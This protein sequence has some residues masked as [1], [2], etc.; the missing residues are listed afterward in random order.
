MGL[1]GEIFHYN[2]QDWSHIT[3]CWLSQTS[4]YASKQHLKI[5]TNIPPLAPQCTNNQF[6]MLMFW[7]NG[8]KGTQ[9]ALLNKCWLWLKVTLADI[10]NGQGRELLTPT[11]MG[12]N[13]IELP[14][15]WHW[16]QQGRLSHKWWSLWH[17]AI[18]KC[19]PICS[20]K[21]TYPLGMWTDSLEDW[22]W[23]QN[24]LENWLAELTEY[25][26]HIWLPQWRS[27]CNWL[28]CYSTNLYTELNP[29]YQCVVVELHDHQVFSTGDD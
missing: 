2:F 22:K 26:W 5:T 12:L 28:K 15:H 18:T 24:P 29:Q 13:E 6:L 16:P 7:Q 10:T 8:Y 1:P 9:L 3:P 4:Q 21:L 14:K 17:K 19:I 25:G 11:L 23:Q 27:H 20:N